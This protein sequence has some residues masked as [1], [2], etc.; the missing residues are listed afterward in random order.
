MSDMKFYSIRRRNGW[1]TADEL[2]RA[3]AE[4]SRVGNEEMPDKV[5]WIRSYVV[6]EGDG[7]IGTVCFYEAT[8]P[9]AIREHA[10]RAGLP[11]NEIAEVG[12]TVVVRTD[13]QA[14]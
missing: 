6:D 5:R 8:G 9:D 7:T 2:D 11:V 13:P 10:E 4:S 3:A 1:K 12:T 14:A